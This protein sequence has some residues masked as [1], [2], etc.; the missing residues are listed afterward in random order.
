MCPRCL[1]FPCSARTSSTLSSKF[2]HSPLIVMLI[3]G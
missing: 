3:A 1:Q 2:P